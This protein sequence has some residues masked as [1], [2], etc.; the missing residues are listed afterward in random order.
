VDE[1]PPA[2][3]APAEGLVDAEELAVEL[4]VDGAR[5]T[6]EEY[7]AAADPTTQLAKPLSAIEE[8]PA[9][10][11]MASGLLEGLHLGSGMR[12]LDFGCGTGWIGHWLTQLGARVVLLDVSE[13]ALELAR[14]RYAEHPPFGDRPAPE[15]LLFDGSTIPLADGSIDRVVCLDALHH[16]PNR[17]EVLRQLAR[18]LRPDGVAAFSEP[19]PDHSRTPQSQWE[20]RTHRAVERDID[21]PRIWAEAQAAGFRRLEVGIHSLQ[22]YR[23]HVEA[24]EAFMRGAGPLDDLARQIRASHANHRLFFLGRAATPPRPDS[25][26]R[27]GLRAALALAADDAAPRAARPGERMTFE[28]AVRNV[29]E[30]DWL[31]LDA[32]VGG[33]QAGIHLL[34]GDGAMLDFELARAPLATTAAVVPGETTTCRVDVEAPATPGAYLLEVD[35]VAEGVAWFGIGDSQ[36]VRRRV[37]VEP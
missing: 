31:P 21:M 26:S 24:F 3:P 25:R 17:A 9:L 15:L 16:V 37:D 4:G 19:G 11:R 7:F 29:G 28:V 36:T 13:T 30:A 8:A 23:T 1:P 35:L 18:V 6:A 10:L 5:R 14:R 27:T 33:V 32:G 22:P 34:S 20:M 12:V 2:Q